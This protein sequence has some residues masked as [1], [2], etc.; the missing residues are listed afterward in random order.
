MRSK[1]FANDN[2]NTEDQAHAGDDRGI[3]VPAFL[4]VLFRTVLR[5]DGNEKHPESASGNKVTE[6]IGEGERRVVGVR[7]RAGTE[8]MGHRPLAQKT[9]NPAEQH[10][11]DQDAG[12][13]Q[14]VAIASGRFR[15]VGM[16]TKDWSYRAAELSRSIFLLRRRR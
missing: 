6:E 4:L 15:H 7:D 5:K 12:G 16:S 14:Q 8:L 11:S 10:H 13:L 9:K 2:Q 1:D 3:Y